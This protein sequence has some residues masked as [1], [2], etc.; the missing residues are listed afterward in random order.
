M[1]YKILDEE[2]KIDAKSF[3][4]VN[5][6]VAEKLYDFV[7]DNPSILFKTVDY[8]NDPRIISQNDNMVAINSC[9][10]LDFMG[11][12]ASES[13]GD[14]QY[15]GTGGQVDFVRGANMSKGGRAIIAIPSTAANGTVSRIV[16]RLG[17]GSIITTSRNDVDYIIT[18]YGIAQLK[19]KTL[20][21]RAEELIAV[22]HP[23]FRAELKKDFDN[24]FN[25]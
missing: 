3:L 15:S 14:K 13:F 25:R 9:I 10:E 7:D 22:A 12:V 5:I 18:E 2:F 4:Q 21:Q 6:D 1:S 16:P 8:T 17:A 23:D 19:G 11:Q 24:I 20:R